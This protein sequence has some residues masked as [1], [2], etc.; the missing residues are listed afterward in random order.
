MKLSGKA[1]S[2]AV[3]VNGSGDYEATDLK[4]GTA[5][6]NVAGSGDC[7]LAVSETLVA[8]VSG[9]GDVSYYGKPTVTKRGQRFGERG[10]PRGGEVDPLWVHEVDRRDC[11]LRSIFSSNRSISSAVT[12]RF[13][14][15]A[16][17]LG[18]SPEPAGGFPSC[19]R[20]FLKRPLVLPAAGS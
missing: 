5:T 1:D 7:D 16:D 12:P 15:R 9:S 18:A 4:T 20:V 14:R 13:G 17:A 11:R 8:N 19:Q 6:I 10:F 2:Q 3:E